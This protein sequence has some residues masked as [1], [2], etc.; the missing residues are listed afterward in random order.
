VDV[1]GIGT[2]QCVTICGS[3][4]NGAACP[5]QSLCIPFS[6]QSGTTEEL[7]MAACNLSTGGICPNNQACNPISPNTAHDVSFCAFPKCT[8][9]AQCGGGTCKSQGYC[10]C[11]ADTD[12]GSASDAN[13]HCDVSSGACYEGCNG[14]AGQCSTGGCCVQF[15][16]ID[17]CDPQ[18]H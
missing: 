17:Y 1:F 15:S 3:S 10:A 16:T 11:A 2:P 13:A 12:C 4:N 18:G 6:T 14:A 7:C 9:A 8:S 5:A